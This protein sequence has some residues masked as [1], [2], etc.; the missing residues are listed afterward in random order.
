MLPW[1]C[2]PRCCWSC[3]WGPPTSPCLPAPKTPPSVGARSVV[4]LMWRRMWRAETSTGA[5][6]LV[7]QRLPLPPS[8]AP[9]MAGPLCVGAA[10]CYALFNAS[11]GSA[12]LDRRCSL[13][14]A[15]VQAAQLAQWAQQRVPQPSLRAPAAEA[16]SAPSWAASHLSCTVWRGPPCC[17]GCRLGVG[18][19]SGNPR[20]AQQSAACLQT[21][22][23]ASS[24]VRGLQ[25]AQHSPRCRDKQTADHVS[26]GG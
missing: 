11:W 2:P 13:S 7:L 21:A 18:S 16:P 4:P 1:W 15:Q 5:P 23:R 24:A 14:P 3:P 9:H 12:H 10:T 26:Q 19:A 22:S 8:R 17:W 25:S 20:A 6:A